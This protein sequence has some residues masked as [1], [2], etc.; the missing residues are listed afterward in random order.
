L[1]ARLV[2]Q[3]RRNRTARWDV[4]LRLDS[5]VSHQYSPSPNY[6]EEITH[7]VSSIT[8]VG[9]EQDTGV[10]SLVRSWEVEVAG[11]DVATAT[12]DRDL[13]TNWGPKVLSTPLYRL[14]LA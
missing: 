13:D 10:G 3:A 14:S 11:G 6:Q 9:V 1:A 7:P 12:S 8:L 4:S 5:A 2:L